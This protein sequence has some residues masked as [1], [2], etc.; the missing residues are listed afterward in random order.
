MIALILLIALVLRLIALNQ[1]F[2]LDEAVQVWASSSFSLAD[3]FKL[4]LPGDFNPPLYHLLLHFWIKLFGTSEVSVRLLPVLLSIISI[5][6]IWKIGLIIAGKKTALVSALLSATSP[7]FI[8]YSQENRMYLLSAFSVLFACWRFLALIKNQTWKNSFSFALSLILVGFSH[9]LAVL[10]LPVFFFLGLK[11]IKKGKLFLPFF[12]F[13]AAY[14]IY[15]PTFLRELE[16]GVALKNSFPIWG[17]TVGSFGLKSV[18]LLPVKFIIGRI[19]IANKLVYG[20][21]SLFLVFLY[22]GAA[23]LSIVET[24]K[25]SRKKQD[26]NLIL[27]GWLLFFPPLIGFLIS[28]WMPVFSYFRFLFVLPFFYL[29]IAVYLSNR[30]NL[31]KTLFPFFV[32]INLICSTTYLFNRNFHRENWRGAVNWIHAENKESSPVIILGQTSKPFEYYDHKKSDLVIVDN[33]SS[34]NLDLS[35][36]D[37]SQVFLVSYSL[38]IFDPK[39][40][41]RGELKDLGYQLEKEKSFR[42]VNLEIW[43]LTQQIPV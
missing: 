30:I 11:G 19:N 4:Y 17:K 29:L 31:L 9:F 42:Q 37:S 28:F 3:F 36:S 27:I 6:L 40:R 14:L 34:A 13:A 38:P 43:A 2:W 1:S 15:L 10:V 35:V 22:W 24:F 21:V 23:V 16:T 33:P 20:F 26:Q 25:L 12:I 18:T 5:W 32:L 8:Y 41:I 7:L 39:D